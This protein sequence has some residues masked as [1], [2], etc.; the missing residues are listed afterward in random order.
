MQGKDAFY[1]LQT[2]GLETAVKVS[3]YFPW[4]SDPR[5]PDDADDEGDDVYDDTVNDRDQSDFDTAPNDVLGNISDFLDDLGG[6]HEANQGE[7]ESEGEGDQ[8]D[9]L[10]PGRGFPGRKEDGDEKQGND[11]HASVSSGCEEL[12]YIGSER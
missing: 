6:L 11:G 2:P 3:A 10:D 7:H 5:L 1:G 8:A 4:Q 12:E 9:F